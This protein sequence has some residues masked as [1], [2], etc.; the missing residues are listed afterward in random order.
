[1]DATGSPP[2]P[3][4]GHPW[5]YK[6]GDKVFPWELQDAVH[7]VASKLAKNLSGNLVPIS[8]A[9]LR[10][11]HRYSAGQCLMLEF[12]LIVLSCLSQIFSGLADA[13]QQV[14]RLKTR[15]F[16]PYQLP[17]PLRMCVSQ[18]MNLPIFRGVMAMRLMATLLQ[19]DPLQSTI[20]E[21]VSSLFSFIIFIEVG[22]LLQ[23]SNLE[24]HVTKLRLEAERMLD[25]SYFNTFFFRKMR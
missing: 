16:D 8:A 22:L 4:Y 1:M 21:Q 11:I 10:G 6:V 15:Q 5:I 14:E 24:A 2:I 13:K 23:L 20:M 7:S 3:N 18:S 9:T 12:V 19:P 25:G 17:T